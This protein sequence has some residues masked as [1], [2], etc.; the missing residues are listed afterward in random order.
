MNFHPL[1]TG[2]IY[3]WDGNT[4]VTPVLSAFP[5]NKV[6][7]VHKYDTFYKIINNIYWPLLY[8]SNYKFIIKFCLKWILKAFRNLLNN[9]INYCLINTRFT[10]IVKYHKFM[11]NIVF[12]ILHHWYN[13]SS[14]KVMF[15]FA[16][17][18]KNSYYSIMVK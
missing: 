5:P 13:G 1:D 14:L 7:V 16:L 11:W 6:T 2:I 15:F 8:S 9:Y 18:I 4:A 12:I 3:H 17:T 10:L